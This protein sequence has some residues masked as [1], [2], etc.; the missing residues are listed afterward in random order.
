[1]EKLR[2]K[3]LSQTPP[4]Y[5]LPPRPP[6]EIPPSPSLL[7]CFESQSSRDDQI[8]SDSLEAPVDGQEED[9]GEILLVVRSDDMTGKH[10]D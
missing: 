9:R 1:M 10:R 5:D 3:L 2:L 8:E 6:P 7:P 4:Q